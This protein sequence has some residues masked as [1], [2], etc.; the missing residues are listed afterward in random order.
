MVC[1]PSSSNISSHQ[2]SITLGCHGEKIAHQIFLTPAFV[3][4]HL[5]SFKICKMLPDPASERPII[6]ICKSAPNVWICLAH[7]SMTSVCN[8]DG[9]V[10]NSN[11]IKLNTTKGVQ[12]KPDRFLKRIWI[13]YP[14]FFLNSIWMVVKMF[15]SVIYYQ[16]EDMHQLPT[17]GSQ[18]GQPGVT[19]GAWSRYRT[20]FLHYFYMWPGWWHHHMSPAPACGSQW[21]GDSGDCG[22]W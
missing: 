4:G 21:S 7:I 2:V 20:I 15:L 8:I 11:S 9:R 18:H 14:G 3:V 10:L 13:D 12:C 22:Y 16:V 5:D 6:D 1:I 19:G 17:V